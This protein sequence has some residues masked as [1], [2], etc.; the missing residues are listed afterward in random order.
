M[1][2]IYKTILVEDEQLARERLR[3][4]LLVHADRI[5][6][7]GEATDGEEGLVLAESIK[8]DLIFLDIQMPI[9]DGF[10]MLKQLTHAAKVI[11]TTA[12]D[13]YAIKA[14]EENSIDYLLKPIEEKRL[15]KSIEKLSLLD[16]NQQINELRSMVEALN[17]SGQDTLTVKLGDR[18]ILIPT[19]EMIYFHAED[20]Y[21]F[22][23]HQSGK[24]HLLSNSLTELEKRLSGSF[25]RI[26]RSYIINTIFIKEI[27][28]GSNGKLSFL[29]KN[30]KSDNLQINSSQTY[31]PLVRRRLGL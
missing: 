10:E 20:K 7:V 6:I 28:K 3:K 13:Q 29:M 23:Y 26:H 31:T 19:H 1:S 21:V 30:P 25:I 2:K 5:D 24:K 4:L 14:F 8:P 27:R 11:F 12:F 15:A 9:M 17:P 16:N 22:G 18:M